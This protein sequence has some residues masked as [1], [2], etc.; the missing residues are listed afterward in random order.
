[1]MQMRNI[2]DAKSHLSELVEMAYAGEEVIICKAGKP[3]VK[4]VRYQ[5]KQ[6]P[7]KPGSWR[8]KVKIADDFDEISPEIEAL[9][10]GDT[11]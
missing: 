4:L 3:L 11:D 8:G 1:M 10:N 6:I 9:F 7:R 5:E 2:H